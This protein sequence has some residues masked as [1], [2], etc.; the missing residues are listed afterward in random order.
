MEKNNI[1]NR[2][3]ISGIKNNPD[4]TTGFGFIEQCNLKKHLWNLIILTTT[5]FTS[6][7]TED[8][9]IYKIYGEECLILKCGN[10][11]VLHVILVQY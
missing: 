11:K 4:L 8:T 6:S 9:S 5:I 1:L 7:S 3:F 2:S 10:Y